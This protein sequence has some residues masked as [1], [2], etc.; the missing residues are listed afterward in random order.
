MRV[1]LSTNY[2]HAL[3][4]TPTRRHTHSHTQ[5]QYIFLENKKVR[6]PF[7]G[8][9]GSQMCTHVRTATHTH[10]NSNILT[11]FSHMSLQFILKKYTVN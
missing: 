6:K 1:S 10:T 4:Y 9:V 7:V 11:D 2:K 3:T 5:S 8:F